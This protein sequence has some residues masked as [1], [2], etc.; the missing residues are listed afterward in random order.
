MRRRRDEE[1]KLGMFDAGIVFFDLLLFGL[2]EGVFG[3][4]GFDLVVGD[5]V[6]FSGGIDQW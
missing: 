2:C 3:N 4:D 5:I 1:D 6:D